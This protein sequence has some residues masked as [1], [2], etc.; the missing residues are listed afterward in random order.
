LSRGFELAADVART[1]GTNTVSNEPFPYVPPTFGSVK[2]RYLPTS[3][4]GFWG[5]AVLSFAEAQTRISSA[6]RADDILENG[7][8]AY[9][10]F[11]IRTGANITSRV[12]AIV[13]V[14]NLFDKAYRFHGS[15]VFEPGRQL[16]I[17]TTYRF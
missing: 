9:Q 1:V 6:E 13:A 12:N 8:P 5:E 11:T 10:V 14:E 16:V 3:K 17:A 4:H 7:T 15:Q 2:L